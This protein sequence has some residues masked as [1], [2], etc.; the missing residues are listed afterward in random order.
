M[1]QSVPAGEDNSVSLNISI[2]NAL[3][4]WCIVFN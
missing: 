1:D 3:C 4:S 2:Q